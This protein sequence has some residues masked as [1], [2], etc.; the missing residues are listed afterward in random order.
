MGQA[1]HV[2]LRCGG[3][4]SAAD[5]E[6]AR[7][8]GDE[9]ANLVTVTVRLR[10]R[11]RQRREGTSVLGERTANTQASTS[12]LKAPNRASALGGPAVWLGVSSL[13]S[14]ED[15]GLGLEGLGLRLVVC[16]DC[17]T[18]LGCS[19][20]GPHVE[21]GSV[22]SETA[23]GSATSPMLTLSTSKRPPAKDRT[24]GWTSCRFACGPAGL[25][26]LAR[27]LA[28]RRACLRSVSV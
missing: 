28:A 11:A 9:E 8:T 14:D 24:A 13:G 18:A 23:S 21:V 4:S 7:L 25:S 16:S 3:P 20:D 6:L 12:I 22:V 27:R 1:A 19:G 2:V 26:S 5:G 10:L 17:A 15:L